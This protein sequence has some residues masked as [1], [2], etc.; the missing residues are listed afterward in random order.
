MFID[1]ARISVKAGSGGSGCTSYYRDKAVRWGKPNGG[2]G[3]NGGD[4][5]IRSDKGLQTLLDFH[6]NRHF[7]A[8]RGTH[9]GS[10]NKTGKRGKDCVL[11][12]PLPHRVTREK[13]KSCSWNLNCW[14]T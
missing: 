12:V 4:I 13:K 3:G 8:E 2:D 7:K 10:N 1:Q 11:R 6:Y 9:G 5:V 14:Q